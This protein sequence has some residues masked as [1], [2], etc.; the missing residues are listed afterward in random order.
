MKIN[1]I[2]GLNLFF[3]STRGVPYGTA[4]YCFTGPHQMHLTLDSRNYC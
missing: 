3:R 2:I 4:Y 1:K